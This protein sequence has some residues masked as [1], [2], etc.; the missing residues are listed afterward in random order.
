MDAPPYSP[1]DTP[2]IQPLGCTL[3]C[4]MCAPH[5][6][7]CMHPLDASPIFTPPGCNPPGRTPLFTPGCTK[8]I[9]P[10]DAAPIFT[11]QMHPHIHP[12]DAPPIF[13]LPM[14]APPYS[15]Q[16]D[17]PHQMYHYIDSSWMQPSWMH[18]TIHPPGCTPKI[19]PPECIP[20]YSPP[21]MQPSYSPLWMHPHIHPPD[22]STPP[23]FTPQMHL[24]H[25]LPTWCSRDTPPCCSKDAPPLLQHGCTP[26]P[27]RDDH[28]CGRY[29][30]YWN[31]FLLYIHF[32]GFWVIKKMNMRRK[33]A[34]P[35]FIFG[36]FHKHTKLVILASGT[37]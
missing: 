15:L 17:A 9:H 32:C 13:T 18:P 8:N 24:P 31:T 14:D 12:L 21:W 37:T 5:T 3:C 20:Q 7:A 33:R 35:L 23:I 22:A 29:A 26:P 19:H 28:C 30:S 1:L 34:L 25:Y 36:L 16:L 10:L 4:S 11:P 2:H 6:A 27:H